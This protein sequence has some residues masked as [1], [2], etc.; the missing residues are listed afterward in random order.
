[1][2]IL[3]SPEEEHLVPRPSI[4]FFNKITL[5]SAPFYASLV[6]VTSLAVFIGMFWTINEF[7][8]YRESIDN[9]RKTYSHQYEVRAQGGVG[10][11]CRT[12]QLPAAAK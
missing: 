6:V 9:I 11:R 10:Q 2:D 8:A 1:M 4:R 3:L 7:Q 5:S 12:D